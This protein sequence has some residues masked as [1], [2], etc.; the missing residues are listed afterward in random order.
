MAHHPYLN[1]LCSART[2]HHFALRRSILNALCAH[3][4]EFSGTLLD[5]GCGYMPYKPVV[6]NPPSRVTKYIGLDLDDTIYKTPESPQPDLGWDGR[7]IPLEDNAVD[8]ALATEVLEHCP[9]PE[10]TLRETRRALR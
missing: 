10:L 7:T 2:L 8:C 5:I 3:L 9:D 4:E 1:P 6:L